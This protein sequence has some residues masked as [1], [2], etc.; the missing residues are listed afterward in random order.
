MTPA[1][2]RWP[3]II[4][5]R[6][7]ALSAPENT[8]AGLCMAAALEV[9]WV[10]FDVK[11]TRDG[12][13]ILLHDDTLD[14]TTNGQGP[15]AALSFEEI[16]RLDAGS[17]FGPD[18]VGQPVPS[19]EE[20]IDVLETLKLGAVVE[21]KPSPGAEAETGRA[22][23]ECVA[24]RWPAHLPAP[25][26]SSFKPASLAAARAVAPELQ[27][28]LLLGGLGRDWRK[29]AEALGCA[30]IHADQRKLD[31]AAVAA[32]RDAGWPLFAYTVNLAARAEELFAWGV[33]AV[34]SDCPDRVAHGLAA[35]I[36]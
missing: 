13:C 7:A 2:R 35:Q 25:L 12:R 3:R 22:V 27:R 24:Q 16:R 31:A 20:A 17:W 33:E 6:G 26:L 15:A 36:I 14:R 19:L 5:H 18:F 8:I 1:G 4:G 23:A 29:Q 30:M 21:I 9:E 28:A 11:L 10:E 32:A 34:F